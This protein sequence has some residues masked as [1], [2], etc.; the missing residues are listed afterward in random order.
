MV[1]N[2]NYP[3][4]IWNRILRLMPLLILVILIVGVQD[5]FTHQNMHTYLNEV[6]QGFIFPTLP[7]GGWSITVEFHYYLILPLFLWMLRKSK[8]LPLSIILAA[9]A[10]RAY[11]YHVNGQIF[12]T[13]YYTIIGRI[14]QFALGMI[15]FNCRSYLSKRHWLAIGTLVSFC[16]FYYYFD[17][18][19]GYYKNPTYPS[20]NPLWIIM[21][22]IE[23]L[24][25]AVGIALYE[26]SFNH[27][28]T[29]VSK[30]IGKMGEYSYSIYLLHFFIVFRAAAFI[31]TKIIDLSNFYF[32]LF[33]SLLFFIGMMPIGYL[34]F[35]F[36]ESPFL[37]LRKRYII[38]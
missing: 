29:G 2:T 13:A 3:A 5:Y 15:M 6:I 28:T 12:E 19:G 11:L 37:K 33:F 10:L 32:A 34:S 16:A 23:G 9:I 1:K 22:T 26:S 18:I 20:P 25:Y 4:F 35:R 7:N 17:A 24:A 27:S 21:P 14:D 36:V 38:Q 8:W 30:L 31:H